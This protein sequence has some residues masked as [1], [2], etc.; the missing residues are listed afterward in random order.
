M[1]HQGNVDQLG[2]PGHEL[3]VR[4]SVRRWG[5]GVVFLVIHVFSTPTA[6][7]NWL[8]PFQDWKH[9]ISPYLSLKGSPERASQVQ[10]DTGSGW[11]ERILLIVCSFFFKS[12]GR[13]F[14]MSSIFFVFHFAIL[15]SI[16]IESFMKC[17][18]SREDCCTLLEN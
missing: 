16:N 4:R 11:V 1:M 10:F 2:H 3:L 12:K 17:N 15:T 8:E 14:E 18:D 6:K 13:C 7:P 9:Q 5:V